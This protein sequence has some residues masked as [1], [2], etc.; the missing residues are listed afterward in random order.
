M[1]VRALSHVRLF[2]THELQTTRLLC[3]WDFLGKNT[4]VGCH[5]LLRGMVP[6]QGWNPCLHISPIAGE[7]FTTSTTQKVPDI[8]VTQMV[9]NLPAICETYVYSLGQEEPL[10]KGIATHS[11]IF[12]DLHGQRSLESYRPWSHKESDM[13]ERLTFSLSQVY[14]YIFLFIIISQLCE[15]RAAKY[16]SL[17]TLFTLILSYFKETM[18]IE[19]QN[20]F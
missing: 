13:T 9:K 1:C 12:G 15:T 19:L 10:G 6:T 14:R 18:E 20:N 4:G 5:F 17:E 16:I 8:E 7:F 11:S 3:P 2:V